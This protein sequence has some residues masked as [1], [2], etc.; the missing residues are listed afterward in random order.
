MT[1]TRVGSWVLGG[2][3]VVLVV[4]RS[5]SAIGPA[6]ILVHGGELPVPIVIRPAIGSFAFMWGGG[7]PHYDTQGRADRPTGLE[8]RR[9][10]S[11]DVFWGRFEPD[12]LKPD[13]ASQHG[14]VYLPT[15][16]E[17]AVVVLTAPAM[18][19]LRDRT[20]TRADAAPIPSRP[21]DFQFGRSL[22]PPETAALVAA[23]VPLS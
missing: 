18:V 22:A 9:Y 6:A 2:A 17:P 13:A 11:Y 5:L 10:L 7:V 16:S 3:F 4:S 1:R 19:S 23:G 8:G 20:A 14:R 12:E 15:A 21:E